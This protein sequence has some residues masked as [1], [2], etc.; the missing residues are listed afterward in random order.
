MT[1]PLPDH[2]LLRI[3]VD[4][5]AVAAFSTRRGGVSA[6]PFASLNLGRSGGGDD[7]E[8]VF[9]NRRAVCAAMGVDPGDAMMLTQVH[10]ADVHRVAEGDTPRGRGVGTF[11]GWP[12][13]DA[14]VCDRPGV[15]LAV[16]AADCVPVLLWHREHPRVG[17][18]HAGWRGLVGGVVENAV[19]AVG[20]P[21]RLGAA[22]GPCIGP[23]H[24]PVSADVRDAFAGRFGDAVVHGEAVDLRAATRVALTT[25]GVPA[26]AI[27]D[28]GG[29]TACHADVFYSHRASGGTTGRHAGLVVAR[30]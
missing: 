19:A 15:L 10:G 7:P 24:Y 2:A 25:A 14:L 29:C 13:A 12:E 21:G 22:V 26:A 3:A 28:A 8:A 16:L 4:G 11:D 30:V 27:T 18:V 9:A 17:A 20:D 1:V 6:G 5:P 23:C